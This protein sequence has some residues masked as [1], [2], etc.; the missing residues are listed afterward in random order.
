MVLAEEDI[1]I[2]NLYK[3][4][5]VANTTWKTAVYFLYM[6]WF[7]NANALSEFLASSQC[8]KHQNLNVRY[9]ICK[10]QLLSSQKI[11]TEAR[12]GC[13][14]N[15]AKMAEMLV[16][17][18]KHP[19]TSKPLTTN[20]LAVSKVES[21]T[22]L[23]TSINNSLKWVNNTNTILKKAQQRLFFQPQFRKPS[24]STHLENILL[25]PHRECAHHSLV[26]QSA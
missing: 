1:V 23:V 10:W 13:E 22:L 3:D 24:I 21:F 8:I 15:A 17:F 5:G 6:Q 2:Q 4:S 12:N 18:R 9:C 26:P 20:G 25:S 14:R 16:D 11:P 7:K 19:S